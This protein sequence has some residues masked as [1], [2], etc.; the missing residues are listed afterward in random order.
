MGFNNRMYQHTLHQLGKLYYSKER[1][2]HA[3]DY[4]NKAIK[5]SFK[6]SLV[7]LLPDLFE[8]KF[9]ILYKLE[10]YE[11]ALADYRCAKNLYLNSNLPE[12]AIDMENNAKTNFPKIIEMDK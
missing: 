5:F 1:Y 10:K 3:L 11:E 6:K 2:D 12:F 9:H 7:R 8:V 4:V